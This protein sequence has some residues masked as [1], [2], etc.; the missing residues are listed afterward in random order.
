MCNSPLSCFPSLRAPQKYLV[1]PEKKVLAEISE[2][3]QRM[4]KTCCAISKLEYLLE[5]VRLIYKNVSM[6]TFKSLYIL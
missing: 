4:M 1:V 6:T 2:V 3:F 5:A